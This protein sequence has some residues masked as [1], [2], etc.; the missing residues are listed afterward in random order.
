VTL[1]DMRRELMLTINDEIQ[2]DA[3][4]FRASPDM[5]IE[6]P[7]VV[8]DFLGPLKRKYAWLSSMTVNGKET[9]QMQEPVIITIATRQNDEGVD[10]SRLK[11]QELVDRIEFM[12][13]K[14]WPSILP[15]YGAAIFYPES[16]TTANTTDFYNEVAVHLAT[17]KITLLE[18]RE[19]TDKFYEGTPVERVTSIHVE[20]GQTDYQEIEVTIDDE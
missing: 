2:E 1:E 17:M 9:W 5:Q 13:R 11:L 16:W 12:T 20:E 10:D 3:T 4:V 14:R 8:V 7:C 6:F 19:S 15:N 18:P